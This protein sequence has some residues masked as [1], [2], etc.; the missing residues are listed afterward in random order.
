[1]R[2]DVN[3]ISGR[4]MLALEPDEVEMLIDMLNLAALHRLAT[5]ARVDFAEKVEKAVDDARRRV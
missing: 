4:T 2:A 5:P 1:M 3:V